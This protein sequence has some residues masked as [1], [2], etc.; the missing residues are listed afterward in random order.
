MCWRIGTFTEKY[1]MSNLIL[2]NYFR[3]STSYRVRIALEHKQISYEYHAVHLLK[4]GGEQ[5]ADSY[6][7]LNPMGGVPTLI[8]NGFVITQSSVIIDYLEEAFPKTTKLFPD[9]IFLKSQV[10]EI[11]QIINADI[12]S[13]GNLKTLQYLEKNFSVTEDQKTKWIQDFFIQGL[14]ALENKLHKT[15][16]K[17][18]FSEKITAADCFLIPLLFTAQRFKVPL[19][20]FPTLIKIESECLKLESFKKAH[21]FCQPDTPPELKNS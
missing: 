3:S 14:T 8:H 19:E 18:S 2:H 1:F 4:N 7:A 11:C 20:K 15:S 9:D 10:K 13:Y 12:H 16:G 21:P 17:Y 5:N 6:R